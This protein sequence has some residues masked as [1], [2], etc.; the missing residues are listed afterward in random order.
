MKELPGALTETQIYPHLRGRG[1][2]PHIIACF[3]PRRYPQTDPVTLHLILASSSETRATL[4]RNAGLV[5]EV[6]PARVDEDAIRAALEAERANPR[7]IADTL[8]ETKARR[9]SEKVPGALVLGCDQVLDLDGRVFAKPENQEAARMQIRALSGRTHQLLSAAVVCRGGEPLWRHLG[10]ARLTM[11]A[12]S[13]GYLDDY[14]S[15]NWQSIRHSVGAYKLEEEGVRLFS[16]I[17]GDHFTI[18]GLP[19]IELLTWLAVRGDIAA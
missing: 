13:D 14:V 4:L 3:F 10:S 6:R 9:I 1:R 19:L 8:A 12:V 18:L 15:R 2:L 11:R 5:P 17:E 16:H 7:D